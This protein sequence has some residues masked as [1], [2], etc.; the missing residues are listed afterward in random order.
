MKSL[1]Y[2]EYIYSLSSKEWEWFAQDVLSCLGY[3]IHIGPSEGVDDGLDMVVELDSVKY[4]VSC[5]H[6][7]ESRKNVGVNKEINIRD[8]IQQHA[9]NGFIAFY[10]TSATTGLKRNLS[11]LK[12]NGFTVVEIYLDNILDIIPEM[13]GFILQKYFSRPQELHHHLLQETKYKPL[14]CMAEGCEKDILTKENI[15]YSMAGFHVDD[16][17]IINLIYGCKCCIGDYAN[18]P[19]WVEISQIQYIEQMLKWRCILDEIEINLSTDFY[20]HWAYLQEAMLQIQIP[21][22][23]GRWI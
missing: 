12:K 2:Q 19:Y 20:Q 3:M 21:Q 15:P 13:P 1:I 22:G 23:W 8:R 11:S 10:S 6:N 16:N 18:Y 4:L 7:Y 17:D 14:I 9:C 5:K